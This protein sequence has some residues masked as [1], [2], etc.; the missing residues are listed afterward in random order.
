MKQQPEEK[1]VSKIS[2]SIPRYII[3]AIDKMAEQQNR[4]RSKMI[5]IILG[6][7]VPGQE[8]P[9]TIYEDNPEYTTTSKGGKTSAPTPKGD[10]S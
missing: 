7:Q 6:D 8:W 10:P 9:S 2:V 1:K 3:D 4:S 5:S